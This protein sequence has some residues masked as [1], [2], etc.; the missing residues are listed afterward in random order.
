MLRIW[1]FNVTL[2]HESL[3]QG[4]H[5]WVADS[6]NIKEDHSLRNG[7][8]IDGPCI[9]HWAR[10]KDRLLATVNKV[11]NIPFFFMIMLPYFTKWSVFHGCI[12]RQ[13]TTNIIASSPYHYTQHHNHLST[14]SSVQMVPYRALF[15]FHI[16]NDGHMTNS[17]LLDCSL[18]VSEQ[19]IQ[20]MIDL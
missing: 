13:I 3:S 6:K 9:G 18:I 19:W 10:F 2:G 16:M 12:F 17:M 7:S 5:Q 8:R 15:D 4:L 20:V 11:E 14:P 1:S